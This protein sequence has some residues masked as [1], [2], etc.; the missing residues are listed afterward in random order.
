MQ[1]VYVDAEDVVEIK[2]VPHRNTKRGD[3]LSPY[4]RTSKSVL[5][6]MDVL[7]DEEKPCVFDHLLRESGGQV[8]NR[9]NMKRRKVL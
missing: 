3:E 8:L 2:C 9:Q 4:F 5:Q 7:L 1:Y 6:Q